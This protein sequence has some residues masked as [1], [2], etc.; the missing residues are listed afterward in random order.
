MATSNPTLAGAPLFITQPLDLIKEGSSKL[1]KDPAEWE[2]EVMDYL[3]EQHPYI[4][5]H[6]VIVA[7]HKSDVDEGHGVGHVKIGDKVVLPFIVESNRLQPL[8]L[9][10]SED[11]LQPLTKAAFDAAVQSHSFG[12]AVKPGQGET[13]DSSITYATLPPF[14]GKYSYGSL[15]YSREELDTALERINHSG[16]LH[17][18][19]ANPWFA[20]VAG[21]FAKNASTEAPEQVKVAAAP[22]SGSL[23]YARPFEKVAEA[24]VWDVATGGG[25]SPGV[26][27]DHLLTFGRAGMVDK[28]PQTFISLGKE[29]HYASS[30]QGNLAGREVDEADRGIELPTAPPEGRC[31]MAMVKSAGA[32]VTEPFD[33]LWAD[34]DRMIIQ[35]VGSPD[36]WTIRM[37][38]AGPMYKEAAQRQVFMN[39]GWKVVKVGERALA[40]DVADANSRQLPIGLSSVEKIGSR[41]VTRHAGNLPVLDTLPGEG[42]YET[43][44]REKLADLDPAFV[45][46]IVKTATN[47]SVYFRVDDPPIEKVAGTSYEFPMPTAQAFE[48]LMLAAGLYIEPD[49]CKRAKVEAEKAKKSIDAILGLNFLNDENMHKFVDKVDALEEAKDCVAHLLLASRLGLAIDSQPLRTALFSLDSVTRDLRE[50]R[51]AVTAK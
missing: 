20:S 17:M 16:Y 29:A 49:L 9:F 47:G 40:I 51:N 18:S 32:V 24:G 14:D 44:L 2:Q 37:D 5:E 42:V 13:S 8:D 15:N 48:S 30:M 33:V 23:V 41:F 28:G 4:A 38:P 10:I 50:L 7:V 25:N 22:R 36:R 39:S 3:H 19:M 26:V 35:P 43:E 12:K 1:S 45:D 6:K 27:F 21:E 11:R 46:T 34:T 31:V